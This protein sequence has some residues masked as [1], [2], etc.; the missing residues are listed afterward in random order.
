MVSQKINIH[1]ELRIKIIDKLNDKIDSLYKLNKDLE[2]EN[3]NL[4][5]ILV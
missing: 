1:D 2:D 4:W 3:K 5:Q